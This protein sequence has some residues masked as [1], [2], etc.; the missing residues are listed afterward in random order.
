MP[1]PEKYHDDADYF[2][3]RGA[4]RLKLIA[5]PISLAPGQYF[6][7][8]R[9]C[10]QVSHHTY[11]CFHDFQIWLRFAAGERPRHIYAF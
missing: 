6:C 9:R 1:M 2:D 3:F 7:R 5:L 8:R 4:S 11:R 10:P